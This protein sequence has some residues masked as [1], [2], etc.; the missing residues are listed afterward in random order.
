[1]VTERAWLWYVGP[2]LQHEPDTRAKLKALGFRY[3]RRGHKLP[4]GRMGSW[5]NS[6]QAPTPLHAAKKAKE[7]HDLTD[8]ELL[9]ALEA[10]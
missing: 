4:D 1:M 9:A 7:H 3:A 6:C 10:V 8:A 5:A 2:S